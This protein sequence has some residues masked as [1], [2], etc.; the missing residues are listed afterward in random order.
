MKVIVIIQARMSSTR[1]PGKVLKEIKNKPIIMNIVNRVS[2][3]K[4]ISKI[5]VATSIEESDNDLY[6]YCVANDINV[7][8]G[9]LDNVLER[10]YKCA[11]DENADIIVRLTGDNPL[12]DAGLIDNAIDIFTNSDIDYIH[13]CKQLPLGMAVEVFSYNALKKA[14][15]QAKNVECKEHVTLYMYKNTNIFKCIQYNDDRLEDCSY[16]RFTVD[17]IDDFRFVNEIYNRLPGN[18]FSYQDV[19]K[20]LKSN[21]ELMDINNNVSQN[22]ILYRGEI[23]A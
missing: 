10:Y 11:T 6:N 16:M 2:M 17:T 14:Y 4:L 12:V 7:Y 22:K 18:E 5:I 13:Y 15:K 3:S 9:D 19:I 21:L 1:L 23:N 8:R 20:M